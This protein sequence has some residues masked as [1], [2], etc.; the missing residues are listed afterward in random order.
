MLSR[1]QIFRCRDTPSA[2]PPNT[3]KKPTP[4]GNKHKP[5]DKENHPPP[6]KPPRPPSSIP[7]PNPLKRKLYEHSVPA[8]SDSGVKVVVRMRPTCGDGD[9]EDSIVERISSDSLFINGQ[10]FT[11]DFVAPTDTTQA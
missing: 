1:N 10:N 8:T 6:C 5:K 9:E 11:F 2:H 3:L 4:T 7:N